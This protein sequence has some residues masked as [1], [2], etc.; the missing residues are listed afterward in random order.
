MPSDT[1][2]DFIGVRLSPET[3]RA[4]EK[5]AAAEEIPVSTW[6]RNQLVASLYL[7]GVQEA[8]QVVYA[9]FRASI[10]D[11]ASNVEE[12]TLAARVWPSLT[13]FQLMAGLITAGIAPSRAWHQATE[14]VEE[15]L[16]A[17]AEGERD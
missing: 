4:V 16:Q 8:P 3:K 7:S 9:G 6:I 1:Q 17:A 12:I 5:A 10:Q 11:I 2:K 14:M 13:K 15:A